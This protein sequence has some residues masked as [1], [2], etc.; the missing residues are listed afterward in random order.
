MKTLKTLRWLVSGDP[1]SPEEAERQRR[2]KSVDDWYKQQ[3]EEEEAR[4]IQAFMEAHAREQATGVIDSALGWI[5]SAAGSGD[6]EYAD[7]S[8]SSAAAVQP[9][10]RAKSRGRRAE[11]SRPYAHAVQQGIA[12]RGNRIIK[13]REFDMPQ[14]HASERASAVGKFRQRLG[15]H[16]AILTG[17]AGGY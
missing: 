7:P 16:E 5:A 1:I 12:E 4:S 9:R 11:P 8:S 2:E 17:A 3:K 15:M 6:E 10:G 14:P 13:A